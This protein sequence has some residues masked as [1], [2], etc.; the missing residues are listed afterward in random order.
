MLQNLWVSK[1]WCIAA[2]LCVL[3]A[4]LMLLPAQPA[5]AQRE[6]YPGSWFEQVNRGG[7]NHWRAVAVIARRPIDT[8]V[9]K[10]SFY[11]P[12]SANLWPNSLSET[13]GRGY[14]YFSW[15]PN[16]HPSSGVKPQ[17]FAVCLR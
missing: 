6:C 1:R 2:G 12:R 10:W 5:K 4:T 9:E 15:P 11:G 14:I 3:V 8:R 16:L 17:A 7:Q 13:Y